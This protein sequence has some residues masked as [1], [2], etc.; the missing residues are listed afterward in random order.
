M[1]PEKYWCQLVNL[2]QQNRFVYRN[3]EFSEYEGYP[4]LAEV[5]LN[6]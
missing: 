2:L 4:R 1:P 5:E 6:Q 3:I